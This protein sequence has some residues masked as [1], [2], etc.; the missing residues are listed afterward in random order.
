LCNI[1]TNLKSFDISNN[2]ICP[3]YPACFEFI[4]YQNTDDCPPLDNADEMDP[5]NTIIDNRHIA[6]TNDIV[7]I[8][9][10]Y[11]QEDL[12]VLKALI[13]YN[14][15]LVG[16]NPLGV[17]KQKWTNMRLSSLDVSS[18]GITYLPE[19]LCNIYS[20]LTTFDM[21]NNEICPPYPGCIEYIGEQKRGFCGDFFC[22]ENYVKI[23][24]GCY[25]AEHIEFLETL[26]NDNANVWK[27]PLAIKPLD[28]ANEG[29]ILIWKNGK[30]DQFIFT[31]SGL[32]NMPENICNVYDDITLFNISNNA[33]C[34]PHPPCIDNVGYQNLDGC[35]VISN[36]LPSCP[37]GC[38]SFDNKCYYNDDVQVLID[39]TEL[40]TSL[41]FYH[42]LLLGHQIWKNNRLSQFNLDGWNITKIPESV[43]KLDRLE[44]LNLNNNSLLI[45]PEGVCE[46]YENL[47]DFQISN[48]LLCPP[49]LSCIDFMGD[50]NTEHCEH[51]FCPYGYIEIEEKCYYEGDIAVLK[52]FINLN[53]SLKNRNPLEI[54]V[55]KWK[56]MRL[57]YLYL[58][59]NELT[60]IPES[61]CEIALNLT[62]LNI[63]RNNVCPPYPVCV[64]GFVGEQNTSD[65]P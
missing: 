22:P 14:E 51:H 39:F 59:V 2:S 6:P 23:D 18:L 49:Y 7:N 44:Y 35:E 3:P 48:N 60:I 16:Q 17:G 28:I 25:H 31:G 37:D 55:Q 24:G 13:D 29:G 46:I 11:F 4:G 65:C 50:Q 8:N 40:N 42:P 33:I 47:H 26:I 52:D 56:N 5:D 62:T 1:Y 15:S 36:P 53:E 61:I 45:I 64:E 32:T 20:N 63:S 58:G 54:G 27:D 10:D 43:Q 19:K 38:V 30:M 41:E 12:E 34:P 9:A 57:D 21:S